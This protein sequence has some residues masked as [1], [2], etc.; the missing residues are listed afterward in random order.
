MP[1][2]H[3][4]FIQ[5]NPNLLTLLN[6]FFKWLAYKKSQC[7]NMKCIQLKNKQTNKQYICK[8]HMIQVK[9]LSV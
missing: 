4:M 2:E 3:K 8:C 9:D 6:M 7:S 1:N 5:L